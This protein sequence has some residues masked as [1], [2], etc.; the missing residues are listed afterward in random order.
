MGK[1]GYEHVNGR[2]T[3]DQLGLRWISGIT[4]WDATKAVHTRPHRH[5]HMEVIFC[6]RGELSYRIDGHDA[7][8][9]G[10]GTGI[11]IPRQTTHV[12]G[13]GTDSPCERIGLHVDTRSNRSPV[14]SVFTPAD[15]RAF[16][17][18]L[19]GMAATP[20][21]LDTNLHS[22][23]RE[24]AGFLRREKPLTSSEL[25]FV[26]CLCCGILFRTVDI[27]SKPLVS[28]RT[29][30]MD[31]AVDFIAR[32]YAEDLRLDDLVRCTGY[33]RTRLFAL[34]KRHTGL[35]PNEYLVRLRIR[36]AQEL[37]VR[38]DSDAAAVAKA[39]GFHDTSYFKRVYLRYTGTDFPAK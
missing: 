4:R 24:L 13:G 11:V 26:R 39:V 25:G 19:S 38:G 21:R 1:N 6:L 15:I 17:R 33:G 8:T 28:P 34:F 12:L 14:H 9:V 27:L 32:H 10:E 29:Q 31:S 35:S 2:I 18:K 20:F 22:A 16:C 5:P 3:S 23:I 36:K 37:A 7:V 30:I